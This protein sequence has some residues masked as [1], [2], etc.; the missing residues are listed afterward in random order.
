M[1]CPYQLPGLGR[2]RGV[3]AGVLLHNMLCFFYR[4]G[5][6]FALTSRQKL[7]SDINSFGN[8]SARVMPRTLRIAAR[9]ARLGLPA[10]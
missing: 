1:A 3:L 7:C 8:R 9:Q 2:G 5:R 10:S 4:R 6:G